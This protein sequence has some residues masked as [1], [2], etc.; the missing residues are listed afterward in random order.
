MSDRTAPKPAPIACNLG[1]IYFRV[2]KAD[3]DLHSHAYAEPLD[4]AEIL[5]FGYPR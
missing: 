1:V 5:L 2:E 4:D 3:E